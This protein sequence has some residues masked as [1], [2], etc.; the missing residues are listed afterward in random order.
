MGLSAVAGTSTIRPM[1][2]AVVPAGA[3]TQATG[4]SKQDQLAVLVARPAALH[5]ATLAAAQLAPAG[6][7][8]PTSTGSASG[9]GS[10]DTY[11]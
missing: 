7:A 5:R 11:L 3:G 1:P 8:D 4:L 9:Q 2:P 6:T 10:L